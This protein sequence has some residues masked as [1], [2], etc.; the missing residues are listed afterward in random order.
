MPLGDYVYANNVSDAAL[1]K[2][3]LSRQALL[4]AQKAT[5]YNDGVLVLNTSRWIK[6]QYM[7]K[8]MHWM[9]INLA[10][11][12][13]LFRGADQTLLMLSF[14]VWKVGEAR[15]FIVVEREWNVEVH[16]QIK[17]DRDF[18]A[19]QAKILHFNGIRKPWLLSEAED[20]LSKE[21]FQPHLKGFNALLGMTGTQTLPLPLPLPA[22]AL[23]LLLLLI[24][25]ALA[26]LLGPRAAAWRDRA[27]PEE[28]ALHVRA[29][30]SSPSQVRLKFVSSL[31]SGRSQEESMR[32]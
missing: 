1:A 20:P 19:H 30:V 2:E 14:E 32:T 24:A 18:L 10:F 31:T 23:A 29:P 15:D 26:L 7:D 5:E 12:G 22:L 25:L 9:R 6:L 28:S 16:H 11:N 21:L 4:L 3:G 17:I 13:K 27:S 8:I